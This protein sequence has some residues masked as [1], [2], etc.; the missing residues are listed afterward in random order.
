MAGFQRPLT[1]W[2]YDSIGKNPTPAEK[3][4]INKGIEY[5]DAACQEWKKQNKIHQMANARLM[6]ASAYRAIGTASEA[7]NNIKSAYDLDDSSEQVIC[8]YAALIANRGEI[9]KAIELLEPISKKSQILGLV[10]LH[11]QLLINRN[12]QNDKN[13][14][15]ELL[16]ERIADI[17]N[18]IPAF[19]FDY[20]NQVA[21]LISEIESESEAIDYIV[22]LS[23]GLLSNFSCDIIK[24]GIYSLGENRKKAIEMALTLCQ[25]DCEKQ[26]WH[27]KR[28]LA[29]LLQSLRQWEHALNIW[30]EITPANYLSRDTGNLLESARR[31]DDAKAILDF[32]EQ[33]RNNQIWDDRIINFELDCRE[34]YNDNDKAAEIMQACLQYCN[35]EDN[36]AIMRL[37]LSYLGLR[38]HRPE[39]LEKDRNKLPE[40][41]KVTP[42][43]GGL[44]VQ[45]LRFSSDPLQAVDYAYELWR[46]HPDDEDANLAYISS[47]LPLGP[48][49]E[50]PEYDTIQDGVAVLY[51]D[52]T[53]KEKTWHII[54]DSPFGNIA[55]SRDEYSVDHYVSEA[56]M[57]KKQGDSFYLA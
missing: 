29:I 57:G 19:R 6:I 35:N 21:L 17:K 47:L 51:E 2:Q 22:K 26:E 12:G 31:A 11:A 7:E 46:L 36:A 8:E 18:T 25:K 13:N 14:A 24:A 9:D 1:I 23:S 52:E 43:S 37:R 28:N 48:K 10:N 4:S 32:C 45:V 34:K 38:T 16:K 15:L 49:V 53:I 5:I 56:M 3:E 20:I 42:Y 30:Q 54:E 40:V 44:V 55:N 27:E 39:L 41:T 33:L 50:L